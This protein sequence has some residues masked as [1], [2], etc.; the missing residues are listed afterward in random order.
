SIDVWNVPEHLR[1]IARVTRGE[2]TEREDDLSA[3]KWYGQNPGMRADSANVVWALDESFGA[4][5][6]SDM[7]YADSLQVVAGIIPLSFPELTNPTPA[8]QRK[9]SNTSLEHLI[10]K[11]VT[12]AQAHE[13]VL[14]NATH[15]SARAGM[16]VDDFVKLSAGFRQGAFARDG[17]LKT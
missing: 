7:R 1:E 16:A 8:L 17:W 2:T 11:P 14:R 4:V 12:E 5:L 10:I 6:R 15:W 9:S 3:F 13:E